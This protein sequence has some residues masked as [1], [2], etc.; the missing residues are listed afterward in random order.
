MYSVF[1]ELS[2]MI[3]TFIFINQFERSELGWIIVIY[4]PFIPLIFFIFFREVI[5]ICGNFSLGDFFCIFYSLPFNGVSIFLN[6]LSC[7]CWDCTG[8]GGSSSG[9]S[10]SGQN[11]IVIRVATTTT[12]GQIGSSSGS[13]SSAFLLVIGFFVVVFFLNLFFYWHILYL[14]L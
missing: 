11:V 7:S 6:C 14:G 13:S 9:S 2:Y 3:I 10:S 1:I 5:S 4:L 8:Y 12:A